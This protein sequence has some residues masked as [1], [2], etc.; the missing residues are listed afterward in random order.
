MQND[1]A[2]LTVGR[3]ITMPVDAP[4]FASMSDATSAN[5]CMILSMRAITTLSNV[6]NRLQIRGE[7]NASMGRL[8]THFRD[9]VC[10]LKNEKQRAEKIA[11]ESE[12]D[13]RG[14]I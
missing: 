5:G 10:S 6:C 3:N 2:A 7:E 14:N 1:L 13:E 8:L 12:E 9:Q 11:E 4:I